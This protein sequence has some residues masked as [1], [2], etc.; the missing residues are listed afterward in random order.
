MYTNIHTC[1]SNIINNNSDMRKVYAQ[2]I[3]ITSSY[4]MKCFFIFKHFTGNN[5]G[6]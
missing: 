4:R 1:D 5:S 2:Q 6:E 3:Y